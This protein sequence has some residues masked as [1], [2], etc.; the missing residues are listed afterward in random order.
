MWIFKLCFY[1]IKAN[2]GQSG[3]LKY[4]AL[5]TLSLSCQSTL[6]MCGRSGAEVGEYR[7]TNTDAVLV[8]YSHQVRMSFPY[9]NTG[10]QS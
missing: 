4:A 10:S 7:R 5:F 8:S 2:R 1:K 6:L 3:F 9:R